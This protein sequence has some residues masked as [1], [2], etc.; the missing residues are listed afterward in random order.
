MQPFETLL[1][2]ALGSFRVGGMLVAMPI[3]GAG[4][5]PPSLKALF[6][7]GI[8]FALF[9]FQTPLSPGLWNS[10]A[11]LLL[12][13]IQEAGVGLILGFGARFFFLV[14]TLM[15]EFAGMQMGFSIASIFDPQSNDQISVLAQLGL[16]LSIVFFFSANFHHDLFRVLV[17]SYEWMPL[18]TF[19]VSFGEV[20][21]R[22]FNFLES[23]FEIAFRLSMPV[24]IAMLVVQLLTG[25][26]SKA[27]PQM[28]LF[29]NA[30]FTVNVI[31]GLILVIFMMP[32]LFLELNRYEKVLFDHAFGLK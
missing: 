18:G 28:N 27:A 29:F 13:V 16:I 3:L 15:M 21:H 4:P 2:I 14:M 12:T 5:F 22:L 1:Q 7:I 23:S 30:L 6:A 10:T 26:L 19:Q 24:M 32:R 31:A 8:S 9:R 17:K 11:A 20:V 25:V